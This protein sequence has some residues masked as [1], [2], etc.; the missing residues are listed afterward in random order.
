LIQ[1]DE[2]PEKVVIKKERRTVK[3]IEEP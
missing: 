3:R 1:K 2:E